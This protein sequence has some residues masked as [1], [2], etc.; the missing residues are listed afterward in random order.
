MGESRGKLGPEGK[1]VALGH[2]ELGG[3]T[4]GWWNRRR[5]RKR[6]SWVQE[7]AV[8][9]PHPLTLGSVSLA[10]CL[11]GLSFLI[12]DKENAGHTSK[13]ADEME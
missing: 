13:V 11:L 3:A 2:A 1:A 4:L 8:G 6:G 5:G 12:C 9:H 10:S 7:W